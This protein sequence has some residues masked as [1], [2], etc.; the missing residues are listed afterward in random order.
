MRGDD[1]T[2]KWLDPVAV[3]RVLHGWPVGRALH[4]AERVEVARILAAGGRGVD[5]VA[6][7]LACS[8]Q[9]ARRLITAAFPLP[10][11]SGTAVSGLC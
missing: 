10:K 1:L 8:G 5:I 9:T 2:P 11:E 7:I 3:D 4:E 6:S